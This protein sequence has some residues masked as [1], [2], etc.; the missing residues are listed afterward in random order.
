MLAVDALALKLLRR[1]SGF[2]E[3]CGVAFCAGVFAILLGAVL[4]FEFENHFGVM[5]LWTYAVFLHGTAMLAAT[6]VL[7]RRRRPRLACVA[8]LTA[9][10]LIA[11]AA[12]AFLIEPHWL[13]I[14]HRTIASRKIHRPVRIVVVADLQTDRIGPYEQYVLQQALNEKPDVLLFAGDYLQASWKQQKTLR[15]Q[16]RAVFSAWASGD[17][18]LP[19]I[20]AVQGNC[21]SDDW[22]EIFNDTG[23]DATTVDST[24]SFDLGDM[25]LTCLR[26]R[27]SFDTSC[28]IANPASDRFHV[29]LGHAPNYALGTVEAD[30]FIAGHT[31]G[32]QVQLPWIGP[33]MTLSAV[34]HGW[35]SGLTRLPS[36]ATLL[37]SRGVGMERGCAPRIRF[38]CRPELMVIDLVP[39]EKSTKER[40]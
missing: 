14:S 9:V 26:M 12:D 11:I 32:G 6:A 5:R 39:E 29:V 36:G 3:W 20:F 19:R 35:A 7:W 16:L 22:S 31:H 37:V 17:S 34:R 28:A 23:L 1:N 10:A 30:L 25:Q 2:W 15:K 21:D 18:T 27:S 8:V 33:P 38:L 4:G 13:E 40:E 24:R